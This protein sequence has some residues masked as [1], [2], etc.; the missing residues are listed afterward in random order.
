MRIYWL[1]I[2]SI[3]LKKII[4]AWY[5]FWIGIYYDRKKRQIYIFPIPC[6]GVMLQIG[7][8]ESMW[9]MMADFGK[10]GLAVEGVRKKFAKNKVKA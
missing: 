2:K 7:A 6:I 5:D 9:K 4:F 10:A 8:S 1:I 3:R